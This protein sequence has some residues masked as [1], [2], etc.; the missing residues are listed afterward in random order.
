MTV[1]SGS[2]I[3]DNADLAVFKE[4]WP[5]SPELNNLVKNSIPFVNDAVYGLM[6]ES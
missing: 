2:I 3:R 6:L 5:R 4:D 1:L